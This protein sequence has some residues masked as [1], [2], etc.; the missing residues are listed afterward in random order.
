MYKFIINPIS[1]KKY[2]LFSKKGKLILKN[3]LK[4][5]KGGNWYLSEAVT[6]HGRVIYLSTGHFYTYESLKKLEQPICPFTDD[7]IEWARLVPKM[8]Y[9]DRYNYSG[10][11]TKRTFVNY[12]FLGDEVYGDDENIPVFGPKFIQPNFNESDVIYY[13]GGKDKMLEKKNATPD[14][15]DTKREEIKREIVEHGFKIELVK[16]YEEESVEKIEELRPDPRLAELKIFVKSQP[17]PDTFGST[18]ESSFL[19]VLLSPFK[20]SIPRVT[21]ESIPVDSSHPESNDVKDPQIISRPR[22]RSALR[23]IKHKSH[24]PHFDKF[25][26]L[27]SVVYYNL[28]INNEYNKRILFCTEYHHL[29]HDI[30]LTGI[31]Y[32][33]QVNYTELYPLKGYIGNLAKWISNISDD[34]LDIHFEY[35]KLTHESVLGKEGIARLESKVKRRGLK[36]LRSHNKD[37]LRLV[38]RDESTLGLIMNN[39][40]NWIERLYIQR[41]HLSDLKQRIRFHAD[42][43]RGRGLD[44][45]GNERPFPFND[46]ELLAIYFGINFDTFRD[47]IIERWTDVASWKEY[48]FLR[49]RGLKAIRA[50]SDQYRI[51][52]ELIEEKLLLAV[53][54]S[55]RGNEEPPM[56]KSNYGVDAM[57]DIYSFFR[58]FR[59]FTDESKMDRGLCKT[60]IQ[61]NIMYFS[62]IGHSITIWFLMYSFFGVEPVYM[63]GLIDSR[64]NLLNQIFTFIKSYNEHTTLGNIDA[65]ISILQDFN[66]RSLERKPLGSSDPLG[67]A[68]F[69]K[70]RK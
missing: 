9:K 46:K 32:N 43:L 68:Y 61:N 22:K 55:R 63:D 18:Q 67:D 53:K 8:Y 54:L 51:S 40:I 19:S 15:I 35:D 39:Y 37:R 23:L 7:E 52:P 45:S 42:D 66:T 5:Q 44:Y 21:V 16:E 57:N 4:N 41:D 2:N 1:N 47:S 58:M 65:F 69:F 24:I 50:F 33:D 27:N 64:G 62:H 25:K 3:M 20:A 48:E 6:M 36:H 26:G 30:N 13:L 60:G 59:S 29:A 14:N 70:Y 28:R 11:S 12:H 49:T 17:P 34:C 31:L 56:H 38:D 10:D